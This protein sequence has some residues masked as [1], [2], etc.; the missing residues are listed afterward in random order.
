[1]IFGT[2]QMRLKSYFFQSYLIYGLVICA[3]ETERK[4]ESLILFVWKAFNGIETV[5]VINTNLSDNRE[6][7]PQTQTS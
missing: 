1:M 7:E 6:V 4:V 2:F 5:A 3:T